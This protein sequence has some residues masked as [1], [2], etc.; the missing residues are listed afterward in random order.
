MFESLRPRSVAGELI[1]SDV[2]LEFKPIG[3]TIAR[4]LPI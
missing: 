1:L 3:V 2:P 4:I